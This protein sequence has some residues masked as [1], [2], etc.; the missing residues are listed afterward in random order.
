MNLKKLAL[1]AAIAFGIFFLINSPRQAAELVQGLGENAGHWF[2]V[3][4]KSLA[5]FFESL[6]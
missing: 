3:A 5:R 6:G 4:G 2:G 1:W